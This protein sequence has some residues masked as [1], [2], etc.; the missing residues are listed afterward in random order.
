VAIVSSSFARYYF[1]TRDPIGQHFGFGGAPASGQV[2]IVGLAADVKLNELREQP[3]HIVYSPIAADQ[4]PN[5][6]FSFS[7]TTLSVRTAADS[8]RVASQLRQEIRAID[9]A[10]PIVKIGT[11]RD[12]VE[13]SLG[14]ERLAAV[15]A[16][17]FGALAAG[18]ACLGLYGVMA[19]SV[20]RRTREFGVR[21]ALGAAPLVVAWSVIRESLMLVLL[22]AATGLAAGL[23][24]AR[25]VESKLFGVRTSDPVTL[26]AALGLMVATGFVAVVIPAWRASRVPPAVALRG[27]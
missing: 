11:M 7:N 20:G 14:Q 16:S 12:E 8:K 18:L 2:E 4:F 22:G 23:A 25:I 5:T 26:A 15:L 10:L 17:A 24:T 3:A 1:G 13:R 19:Y 9:P 21:F 6:S 27:D